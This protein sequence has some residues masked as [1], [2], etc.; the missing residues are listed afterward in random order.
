MGELQLLADGDD[1]GKRTRARFGLDIITELQKLENITVTIWPDNRKT[2]EGVDE[3][4]LGLAKDNDFALATIDYN[5]NKVAK[6]EDIVVLNMNE[7]AKAIKTNILPGEKLKLKLIQEGQGKDQAVGYLEDGSMVVVED[8]KK[9]IG[10]TVEIEIKRY[11]Q[12]DAGKMIF[13][14]L[15]K[16]KQS[17]EKN[18]GFKIS[19]PKIS[20]PNVVKKVTKNSSNK[21]K[22][23]SKSTNKKNQNK[24]PIKTIKSKNS[25][26]KKQSSIDY[27]I[28]STSSKK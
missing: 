6:V 19:L 24:K 2:P 15:L 7:L 21:S 13:A 18:K 14:E 17:K 5:L 12:T 11:L 22:I 10:K 8:G 9:Q 16:K 28:N 4:L 23:A 25:K 3:R 27:I 1:S 26:K 20:A